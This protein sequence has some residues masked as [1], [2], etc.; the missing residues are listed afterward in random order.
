[1]AALITSNLRSLLLCHLAA[2]VLFG[3]GLRVTGDAEQK[4]THKGFLL[5]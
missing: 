1:M 4:G 5:C 3:I 2:L